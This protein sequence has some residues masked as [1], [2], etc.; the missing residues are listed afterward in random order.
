MAYKQDLTIA[1]VQSRLKTVCLD[2]LNAVDQGYDEYLKLTDAQDG[3]TVLA[4]SRILYQLADTGNTTLTVDAAAKTVSCL[5]GAGLFANFRVGRNIQ[6]TNFT[7][8]GNLVT[9]LITAKAS[10]DQVTIGNETGLVNETDTNARGQENPTQPELD[11]VTAVTT[12]RDRFSQLKDA[13]DNV[14]VATADRRADLQ[15][16]IW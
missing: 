15:D 5:A 1:N 4:W 13:I 10:D 8:A 9:T 11:I 14:A 16:W 3:A 2:L 7:N 6:F 12:V